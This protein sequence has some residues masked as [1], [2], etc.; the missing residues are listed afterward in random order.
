MASRSRRPWSDVCI[1][2]PNARA[3]AQGHAAHTLAKG[4]SSGGEP[5]QARAAQGQACGGEGTTCASRRLKRHLYCRA[6]GQAR[7]GRG[8]ARAGKG[9]R[10]QARE[11]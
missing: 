4:G 2:A 3:R 7:V 10:G 11:G 5:G 8:Q 1:A 9:R 6:R